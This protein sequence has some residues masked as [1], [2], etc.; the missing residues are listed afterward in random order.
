MTSVCMETRRRRSPSPPRRIHPISGP[1]TGGRRGFRLCVNALPN[2]SKK[3]TLSF[4]PS[5]LLRKV[6]RVEVGLRRQDLRW[7]FPSIFHEGS[8]NVTLD[9]E[10]TSSNVVSLTSPSREVDGHL[11]VPQ[12]RDE[13]G[14][15]G[16]NP[17]HAVPRRRHHSGSLPLEYLFGGRDQ[18]NR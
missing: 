1:Q 4:F 18:T 7:L 12:E 14:V 11:P 6:F 2:G 9:F 15:P 10:D 3:G 13:R 5:G 8:E 16:E 17:Y